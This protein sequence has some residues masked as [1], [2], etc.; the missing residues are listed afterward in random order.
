MKA[1]LAKMVKSAKAVVGECAAETSAPEKPWTKSEQRAYQKRYGNTHWISLS[2]D[3]QRGLVHIPTPRLWPAKF[4]PLSQAQ[5]S[6]GWVRVSPDGVSE[7]PLPALEISDIQP[8]EFLGHIA[9]GKPVYQWSL[10]KLKCPVGWVIATKY[11]EEIVHPDFPTRVD[12]AKAAAPYYAARLTKTDLKAVVSLEDLI[13]KSM[14][15]DA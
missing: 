11:V 13:T 14:E 12:A 2:P 15:S 6:E 5:T 10:Q 8:H 9:Q 3:Q 7:A 4:P 1:A